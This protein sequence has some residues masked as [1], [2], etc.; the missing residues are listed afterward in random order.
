MT[1]SLVR[2]LEDDHARLDALLDRAVAD[3]EKIDE[4]AYMEFRRGLLRHIGIEEKLFM[5]KL[6]AEGG[7][8]AEL[9]HLIRQEHSAIALL[10]VP[11][12]THALVAELR[13]LLTAHNPL[14]EGPD[15]MYAI[16]ERLLGDD[17]AEVVE[18]ARNAPPV[19]PA[20]YR[21]GPRVHYTAASA[22]AYARQ[23]K[24]PQPAAK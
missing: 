8:A 23:K 22:L 21:D 6:R 3:P 5:S 17:L 10:L 18:K 24:P 1:D 12:P 20:P 9:A 11:P 15:G 4:E 16:A 2:L 14:E 13:I 7:E 19:P